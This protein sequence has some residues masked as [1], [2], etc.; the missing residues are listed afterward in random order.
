MHKHIKERLE[1]SKN[2]RGR[3]R[4]YGEVLALITMALNLWLEGAK[5]YQAAKN[6]PLA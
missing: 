6:D 5:M 2:S 4:G 3:I 1:L